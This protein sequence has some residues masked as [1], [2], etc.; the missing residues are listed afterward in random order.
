MDPNIHIPYYR[1]ILYLRLAIHSSHHH[2]ARLLGIPGCGSQVRDIERGQSRIS[3]RV[4]QRLRLLEK[5]YERQL[6]EYHKKRYGVVWTWGKEIKVWPRWD[7]YKYKKI[8]SPVYRPAII[9]PDDPAYIEAL[10]GVEAFGI[11]KTGKRRGRP[12]KIKVGN[13][14]GDAQDEAVDHA[15]VRSKFKRDSGLRS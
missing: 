13:S 15:G 9:L 6:R 4:I 3:T 8:R 14:G 7:G 12:P 2:L 11:T 10:G 1:R 5:A